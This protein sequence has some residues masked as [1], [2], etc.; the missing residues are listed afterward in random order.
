MMESK[1]KIP[2]N[3]C[4]ICAQEAAPFDVA[5]RE[6]SLCKVCGHKFVTH[7]NIRYA[8]RGIRAWKDNCCFQN[9]K[10]IDDGP[11]WDTFIQSRMEKLHSH[12]INVAGAQILS[13]CEIGCMEGTVLYRAKKM[14]HKVLGFEITE[15]V[16]MLREFIRPC[17]IIEYEGDETF[18]AVYSFH[19]YE[20]LFDAV[21][22]TKKIMERLKPGGR[23]FIEVPFNDKDY[24]NPDHLHFY[25]WNS[26]DALLKNYSDVIA[27]FS[28]YIDC[29]K[30]E[31]ELIQISGRK[32]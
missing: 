10:N 9:I 23:I 8:H 11:E 1:T 31:C 28:N 16:A 6:M 3:V 13:L 5:G 4:P 24:W 15:D 7:W 29:R 2:I 30:V 27:T 14:G 22:T 32:P 18:D 17:S 26:L 20:H 19:V 25:T 21:E 12:R